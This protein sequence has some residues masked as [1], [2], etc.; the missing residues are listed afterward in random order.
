MPDL[1]LTGGIL[2]LGGGRFERGDLVVRDGS[3]VAAGADAA[4]A[5]S[6]GTERIDLDGGTLLPGFHD[7]HV[8]PLF[9]GTT[10]LGIDLHTVH[11]RSGYQRLVADFAREHPSASVLE[12]GG[13]FGDVFE[14]GFP[15]A[16]VLDEVVSDRPVLLMSH[17]WHGAWVNSAALRLAGIDRHTTDP[18]DGRIV[19]DADG[20]PT[21]MLIEGAVGL[22][23][24]LL[25]EANAEHRATALLAAQ[26]RL[27]SVGITSW[28]DAAVGESDIG[29]DAFPVYVDIAARGLLTAR[30]V[31]ALWWD[32]NLGLEQI[33]RLEE[34]RRVAAE[35]GA[36]DAST[37][38]VM[39]DGMVENG[40]AA[41]LSPYCGP[42]PEN[43]GMAFIDPADLARLSVE[44]DARDFQIHYHAVGDRAVRDCLDAVAAARAANGDR[45]NRHHIAHLDIVDPADVPRFAELDVTA[46]VSPLW[47]RRDEEIVTRKLPLLGHD[48]E[49]SHFPFSSLLQADAR[50]AGGSDWPVT[51]PNPLWAVYTAITRTAPIE[52]LHAVGPDA[53]TVPLEP[54]E[55]VD[56]GSALDAYLM[57]AA[58]V[59]RL[60]DRTG[61]LEVG[62][63]ADLVWIDRDISDP[64]Q[65]GAATVR[66]TWVEGRTVYA[67]S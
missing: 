43:S 34:R 26:E 39:Q 18:A 36:F 14:G 9:A 30:V 46:N 53:T 56:L 65:L 3:I 13:W 20:D 40:S 6:A 15:T 27:H 51:D 42:G 63:A 28:Q 1:L 33:D 35:S 38:K 61:S 48:R 22:V 11:S 37:V 60:D 17:D 52:D 67:A 44:L 4:S 23:T 32:R 10:L 16:A 12:G 25:P 47:A 7:A 59:N 57:G 64:A 62:K 49:R 24:G 2:Y 21:G 19:R 54:A 55:A 31:A 5:A 45:G 58:H 50:L 66:R 29:P 41:M 8:H